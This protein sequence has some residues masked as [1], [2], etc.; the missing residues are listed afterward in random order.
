M[1]TA[2]GS[3]DVQFEKILRSSSYD[4]LAQKIKRKLAQDPA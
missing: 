3:I 1:Q 4:T 2:G